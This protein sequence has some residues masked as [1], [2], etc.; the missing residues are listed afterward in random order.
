ME[1]GPAR[2]PLA[3]PSGQKPDSLRAELDSAGFFSNGSMNAKQREFYLKEYRDGLLS[4]TLPFWF[5]RCI[6]EEHSGFP[7]ARDRDGSLLDDDKGMWQ[8][9]RGT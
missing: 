3:N 7:L 5:P 2:P 4:N 9:C 6:D 8:Q 1:C